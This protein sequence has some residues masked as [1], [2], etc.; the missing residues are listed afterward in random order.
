MNSKL[1]KIIKKSRRNNIVVATIVSIMLIYFIF[2]LNPIKFNFYILVLI[3]VFF[4]AQSIILQEIL[5]KRKF[6]KTLTKDRLVEFE[7]ELKN[8]LVHYKDNYILTNNYI[9]K[10][11]VPCAILKYEEV[12]LMYKRLGLYPR[13]MKRNL[14][15]V[16][17]T[18]KY[19]FTIDSVGY[20][21]NN[22]KDFSEI[23]KEKNT[24]VL[25]G[26][27]ADNIKKAK[28]KYGIDL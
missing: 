23:V 11:S 2:S 1:V 18:R 20:N 5:N 24:E 14:I 3:L 10:L 19:K 9:L 17:K 6:I 28:D 26:K 12:L 25:I 21:F 4:Y 22:P 13:S 15:L 27:S 16:T 8:Q 7:E